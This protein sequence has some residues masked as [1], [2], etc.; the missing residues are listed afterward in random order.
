MTH[1]QNIRHAMN[2]GLMNNWCKG[3][4]KPSAI[5]TEKQVH[6]VCKLLI[7][8]ATIPEIKEK[9]KV[10]ESFIKRV[11]RKTAWTYITKEYDLPPVKHYE[12]RL[13]AIKK[14]IVNLIKNDKTNEEIRNILEL[15][16]TLNIRHCLNRYRRQTA[17][18]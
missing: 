15:S 9:L 8:G 10:P 13:K 6:Q 11:Q 3:E 12:L 18:E 17:V 5:Y 2:T 16:D 4:D 14:D 7:K 1:K